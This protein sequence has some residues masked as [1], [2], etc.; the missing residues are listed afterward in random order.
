VQ[1]EDD[2][3]KEADHA[4]IIIYHFPFF[5]NKTEERNNSLYD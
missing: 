1:E 2:K 5:C 3:E 4:N